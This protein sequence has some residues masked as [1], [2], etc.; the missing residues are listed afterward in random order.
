MR[1]G[2]GFLRP[3]L[4]VFTV[5]FDTARANIAP[6]K[7]IGQPRFIGAALA[8]SFITLSFNL[9]AFRVCKPFAAMA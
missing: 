5:V 2:Q 9:G 3:A 7:V 1:C 6:L 8:S 4:N